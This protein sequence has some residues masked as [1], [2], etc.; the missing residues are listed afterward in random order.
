MKFMPAL[1]YTSIHSLLIESTSTVAGLWQTF[2]KRCVVSGFY[3]LHALST[4]QDGIDCL[5]VDYGSI[6]S[7]QL[8][9]SLGGGTLIYNNCRKFTHVF[10]EYS[11]ASGLRLT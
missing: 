3:I 1:S 2:R 10:P 6:A 4:Y 8:H 5:E 7:V 11:Q 9:E